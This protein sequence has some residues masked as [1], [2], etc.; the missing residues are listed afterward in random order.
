MATG[1]ETSRSI[2]SSLPT[3]VNGKRF[4]IYDL[5][6][7]TFIKE[8]IAIK[9]EVPVEYIFYN[10]NWTPNGLY[11]DY[12]T[13]DDTM[14]DFQHNPDFTAYLKKNENSLFDLE[15]HGG[16][17]D[18]VRF[19]F[20]TDI[21]TLAKFWLKRFSS[22]NPYQLFQLEESLKTHDV[23]LSKINSDLSEFKKN[24]QTRITLLKKKTEI[25][26]EFF[27]K[28]QSYDS[29]Y[30]TTSEIVKIKTEIEFEVDYDVYELFNHIR[31]SR[32]VPFAVI[33][34]YYKILKD[35]T[36][37][38]KWTYARERV[39]GD[40][41]NKEDVLY[42]KTLNVKNEPMA[43]FTKTNPALYSTV[44]IVFESPQEETKRKRAERLKQEE[45]QEK[46]YK[47]KLKEEKA[48]ADKR[49]KEKNKKNSKNISDEE[50]ELERE[51]KKEEQKEKQRI[52]EKQ[53][54]IQKKEQEKLEKELLDESTEIVRSSKVKLRV[55]SVVNHE[56]DEDELIDRILSTFPTDIFVKSKKQIHIKAEFLV[57]DFY[58][59]H[60]VFMDSIFNNGMLNRMFFVDERSKLQHQKEKGG[61][62][63]YFAS[64]S[65]DEPDELMM[66]CSVTDQLVEKT[67]LKIIARDPKLVVGSNYLR[68][69]ITRAFDYESID[70]FRNI[71]GRILTIYNNSK[72]KIIERYIEFIPEFED[73]IKSSRADF[74][75]KRKKD[76]RTKSMLKDID[77]DQFIAGYSRWLCPTKRAPKITQP[78]EEEID[79]MENK[80]IQT[81]LFPKNDVPDYNQYLYTCDHHSEYRFPGLRIN[82]LGNAEKYPLVPCCYKKDH[83]SKKKSIWRQYYE[84][85]KDLDDFRDKKTNDGEDNNIKHI[86]TTNKILPFRRYGVL[87]RNI[88][89]YFSNVDINSRYIRQGV[90]RGYSSIIETLMMALDEDFD[91]YT[92]DDRREK[93]FEIRE[94]LAKL[95]ETSDVYQNAYIY[96]P[97]TIKTYLR[98]TKKY[99]DPKMFI[100]L[101]EEYFKVYIFI[102]SQNE[103]NPYG[104]LSCPNHVKE[105]MRNRKDP[106]RKTVLIYEHMG[107][108]LDK[109]EYPQCELIIRI[110]S[111]EKQ[112]FIFT[113]KYEVVK[114]TNEI[115]NE[116]YF[117]HKKDGKIFLSFNSKIVGQG[118]DYYGKTRFLEFELDDSE[119][120]I[121]ILTNPIPSISGIPFVY[122]YKTVK[123]NLVKEW[124]RNEKISSTTEHIVENTVVGIKGVKGD[125]DF[126]IPL[127]ESREQSK[128]I[129][130]E[131]DITASPSFLLDKS[132][133]TLYN[134]YH[135]RA[136]CIIEYMLYLFSLFY[137]RNNENREKEKE[138][139]KKI[140][141]KYIESFVNNCITIN[142][143]FEYGSVNR[144]FSLTTSGVLNKNKLVLHNTEILK[145][146]IYVLRVRLRDNMN[147]VKNYADY[148]YIQHYYVDIK[149]FSQTENQ[150]IIYGQVALQKWIDN[151]KPRYNL[152]ST[153][154]HQGRTLLKEFTESTLDKDKVFCIVFIAEWHAPSKNLM[155]SIY[156]TRKRFD[157]NGKIKEDLY[158][159]YSNKVN[160][161]YVNIDNNKSLTSTYNVESIPYVVFLKMERDRLTE[162]GKIKGTENTVENVKI[163]SKELDKILGR[164]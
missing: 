55:E 99:L 72:N 117:T 84:E 107:S 36:P 4:E 91:D 79:K 82:K 26:I 71:F 9:K 73:N 68:V 31:M 130:N 10:F 108:E 1:K 59:D 21:S 37:L 49:K 32:D 128:Y 118:I 22:L 109:A 75:T 46:N 86:Y 106:T 152:V 154:T 120:T 7:M 28:F 127:T 87:V 77:P 155:N 145:K 17:P 66:T 144:L 123:Y 48:M 97:K 83:R 159:K 43:N 163:V 27:K 101:L 50:K 5:D 60:H 76:S 13:I 16:G 23:L 140:D 14:H 54:E 52:K 56:F 124:L 34:E 70:K 29:I 150:P 143:E 69:R 45:E 110:G 153:I 104:V 161:V 98:D 93:I 30:S 67:N 18:T 94:K 133:L 62:Y 39:E 40:F 92:P 126:Y 103:E 42:L 58:M 74:I 24:L 81:M 162:L 51:R 136:R 85:D 138:K 157:K 95:A 64:S 119:E 20:N 44:S 19:Q 122:K 96:T 129:E 131:K 160:F 142:S 139:E 35:F 134:E 105:Y 147:E 11:I 38:T 146:L 63:L 121:C 141:Q 151:K 148:K 149:D 158:T 15:I 65:D 61:V 113:E 33:G 90:T 12:K 89:I 78:T 2:D 8:R 25:D 112:E 114:R 41:G 137:R 132:E 156:A 88:E 116:M 115:F 57:P 3:F 111:D 47:K 6:S 135:Q 53:K 100:R 80:G 125:V 102:F 164:S